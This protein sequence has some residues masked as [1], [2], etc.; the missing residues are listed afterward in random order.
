MTT[1]HTPTFQFPVYGPC[2]QDALMRTLAESN[3]DHAEE[4]AAAYFAHDTLT[5]RV[6]ELEAVLRDIVKF[7]V[8]GD[9]P[10]FQAMLDDATALLN[11]G[12]NAR[13]ALAK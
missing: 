3:I 1:Q 12:P 9:D 10:P 11:R 6:A 2:T 13:A 8:A 7:V 4:I 5:A